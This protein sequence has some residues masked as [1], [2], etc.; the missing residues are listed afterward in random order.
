MQKNLSCFY[1]NA[2][3][4]FFLILF[5]IFF[6]TLNLNA[7]NF[8][9]I[10]NKITT[11]LAESFAQKPKPCSTYF[12]TRPKN[13]KIHA[14][15]VKK[16]QLGIN[17]LN[18]TELNNLFEMIRTNFPEEHLPFIKNELPSIVSKL[19]SF[20]QVALYV[21]IEQE[22]SS[23]YFNNFNFLELM[24]GYL[25]LLIIKKSFAN[26][27]FF[28]QMLLKI[29][30]IMKDDQKNPLSTDSHQKLKNIDTLKSLLDINPLESAAFSATLFL[31]KF[32]KIEKFSELFLNLNP[33]NNLN[34]YVTSFIVENEL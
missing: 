1:Q 13:R 26:P 21:K 7:P 8:S 11:S 23:L 9:E 22:S 19:E 33:M 3:F 28:N 18:L 24:R 10:T 6:D 14:L 30:D 32:L 27:Y 4:L 20:S 16:L 34:F 31:K 12:G 15:F 5:D 25:I 29:I 2:L 17:S